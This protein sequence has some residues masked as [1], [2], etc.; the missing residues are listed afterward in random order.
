MGLDSKVSMLGKNRTQSKL[1]LKIPSLLK[2]TSF[3]DTILYILHKG[4][5]YAVKDSL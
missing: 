3:V 5:M 4:I 1:P 2:N